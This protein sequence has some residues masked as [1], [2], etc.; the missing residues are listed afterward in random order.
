ME[1]VN[2]KRM[3]RWK[4]EQC[5][6]QYLENSKHLKLQRMNGLM[7]AMQENNDGV[8]EVKSETK[9]DVDSDLSDED[10]KPK[11]KKKAKR[12]LEFTDDEDSVET[13]AKKATFE[14]P[15]LI[16]PVLPCIFDVQTV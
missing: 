1:M 5:V 9:E 6:E 16:L 15:L 2:L 13:N 4:S 8:A 12:K 3:G 11:R 10:E 14:F 7:N